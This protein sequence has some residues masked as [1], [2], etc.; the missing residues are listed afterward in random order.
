MGGPTWKGQGRDCLGDSV[1]HLRVNCPLLLRSLLDVCVCVCV[2][3]CV[4]NVCVC[5][6]CVYNVCVCV[7]ARPHLR[8]MPAAHHLL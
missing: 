5:T 4:Y 1:E 7:R 8:R 6:L 3:V 2:C